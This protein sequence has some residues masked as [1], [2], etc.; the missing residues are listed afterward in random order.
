MNNRNFN[1]ISPSAKSIL[2]LK[3]H[4]NLPFAKQ[5]AELVNYPDEFTPDFDNNDF[6]FWLSVLHFESRYLSINQLLEDLE[7]TNI[8][9]LSAGF[10]FRGLEKITQ[11]NCHYI[12]TDLPNI[13]ETKKLILEKLKT[14][15]TLGTLE[16]LSLNVLDEE[17]FKE[18][19]SHFPKGEIVILNEGL[20]I[21]LDKEEKKKLCS[22]IHKILKN[23]GGYWIT[24]DIYI[25]TQIQKFNLK[26]DSKTKEF[27][28]LHRIEKNKFTSF[29]EAKEFFESNGFVIDKEENLDISKLS[30]MEYLTRSIKEKNFPQDKKAGKIQ[31]T[32]RLRVSEF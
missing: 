20:L 30:S 5:T 6:T 24:A 9:E 1:T 32:W 28:E 23:R 8:L 16:L 29:E 14:K 7:I 11:K 2:L 27:S 25:K 19:I 17:E 22:S 15:K 13:I 4:T 3:G 21:Y 12:D 31:T 10:S 18:V 26:I